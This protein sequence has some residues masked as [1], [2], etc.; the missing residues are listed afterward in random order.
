MKCIDT[1]YFID[2]IRRPSA[3]K[4]ITKKLDKKGTHATT[5]F[6]VYEA[7]FGVYTLKDIDRGKKPENRLNKAITN[8]KILDFNYEDSIKASKIGGELKRKGKHVGMDAIIAAIAINNGCESIVTRNKEH[9]KWI[10]E[11]TGLK[12]ELYEVE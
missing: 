9:F 2:L 11:I 10:E 5:V 7:L 6:N 3:I 4:A 12:V 8:M 1:T